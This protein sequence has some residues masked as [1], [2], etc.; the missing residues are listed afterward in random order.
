[1]TKPLLA[2]IFLIQSVYAAAQ[3]PV[4]ITE[5]TIKVSALGEEIFY[6]GFAAGDKLLFDF[7]EINGKA[8]K[9]L[10]ISEQSGASVFMDYRTAKLE[11]KIMDVP[12][13]GIYKFRFTNSSLAG[14][15]CKIKI[16]RI[17]ASDATREFNT[18]VYWHDANDTIRIPRQEK[19]L[20]SSDT[21]SITVCDQLA[22]VSSKNALNR[23]PNHTLV[24]FDLPEG[25]ISWSY[26]IGVG[27]EGQKAYHAA[28]E[29]LLNTAAKF[30]SKI[31]GYGTMAALALYGI[32]T[33]NKAQDGDNV[34]YSFIPDLNNVSLYNAGKSY[35]QYRSGNVIND[36]GQMKAPLTGKIY[37]ALLNDNIAE[38]I[39]VVVKVTAIQVK[40]QWGVRTTE[41]LQVRKF[42][43]AYLKN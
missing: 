27:S 5:R 37:I 25:T 29:Q 15:I 2:F 35:R 11:N 21:V 41:E 10:E 26:Y 32:N 38:S 42:P 1:M 6:Y 14:R 7:E 34:Q 19:Y 40:Q 24:D 22:K 3:T 23:N 20:L 31:P 18:T 43:W 36:A 12:R 9:E 39:D 17:P 8:L 13:T 16:Q 30:S 4:A 33:F 28:R